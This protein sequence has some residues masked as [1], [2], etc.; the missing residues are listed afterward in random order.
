M[1]NTG[2]GRRADRVP[3]ENS[4][5]NGIVTRNCQNCI[6]PDASSE[7]G[8]LSNQAIEETN[9]LLAPAL[10]AG[11][12]LLGVFV[13]ALSS[14]LLPFIFIALFFVVVLSLCNLENC[15]TEVMSSLD[16]FT[17]K[18]VLWQLVALPLCLVLLTKVVHIPDTIQAMMLATVTASSVF[19]GPTLVAI[20]GLNRAQATRCMVFSTMAMPISLLVFGTLMGIVP[21]G[22]SIGHYVR[23]INFFL[24]IPMIIAL[25]YWT[26]RP[27]FSAKTERT[28]SKGLDCACTLALMVFCIGAMASISNADGHQLVRVMSYGTVAVLL[29]VI[30]FSVTAM[31]FSYLGPEQALLAGMLSANRNIA[32][33]A[34]FLDQIVTSDLMVYVAVSQFPIFMFPIVVQLGRRMRSRL[35]KA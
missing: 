15:P 17:I 33:A 9:K 12:V 26:F 1:G 30:L 20:L 28:M 6:E 16:A 18:M 19:A 35:A 8:G 25:V 31:V 10:V 14:A 11:A 21:W 5:L 13:P 3:T 23:Q 4:Y 29:A 22:L 7:G 32:L 27:N 2:W 24:I 34:A